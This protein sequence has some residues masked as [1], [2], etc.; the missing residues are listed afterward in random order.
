MFLIRYLILSFQPQNI[1]KGR[2]E[3]HF[4]V[5]IFFLLLIMISLFPLNFNIMKEQGWSLGFMNAEFSDQDFVDRLPEVTYPNWRI[6]SSGLYVNSSEETLIIDFE[7]FVL[8]INGQNET[9]AFDK[10]FVVLNED[11]IHYYI[12]K[13]IEPIVTDYSYF[14]DQSFFFE[15]INIASSNQ[16]KQDQYVML[17]TLVE[18]AFSSYSILG[19]ILLHTISQT[20]AFLIFMPLLALVLQLFRFVHSSYMTYF[21]GL[22]VVV[23]CMGLPTVLAF[24]IGIFAFQFVSLIMQFGIGIMVMVIM[25]KYAKSEFA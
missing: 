5:L 4:K 13:D 8:V 24:V 19:S 14:H 12:S 2:H 3:P 6:T 21:E 15:N 25:F 16:L 20:I 17:G 10:K 7:S 9:Y 22:N 11:R 1:L 18:S 23:F